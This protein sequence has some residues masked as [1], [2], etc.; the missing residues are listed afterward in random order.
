MPKSKKKHI[1]PHEVIFKPDPYESGE[2]TRPI[3]I[4]KSQSPS[5]SIPWNVVKIYRREE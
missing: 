2:D 1:I 3:E 4:R 5:F